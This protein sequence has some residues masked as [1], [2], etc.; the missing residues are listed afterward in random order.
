VRLEL[1]DE[2][3]LVADAPTDPA[4]IVSGRAEALLRL[5]YGRNRPED[6]ITATGGVTLEDLRSLFPGF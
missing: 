5:I 6:G 1:G 4:G 3:H 2:L